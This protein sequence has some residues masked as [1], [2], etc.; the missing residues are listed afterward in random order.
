MSDMFSKCP[1]EFSVLSLQDKA[2]GGRIN[3]STDRL[4]LW[5]IFSDWLMIKEAA[6]ALLKKIRVLMITIAKI[7]VAL[8]EQPTGVTVIQI[9]ELRFQILEFIL[10]GDGFSRR[11]TCRLRVKPKQTAAA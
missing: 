4:S 7:I 9:L 8:S 3:F 10:V 5:D 1:N 11:G 2:A 6:T